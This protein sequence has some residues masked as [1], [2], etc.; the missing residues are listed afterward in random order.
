MMLKIEV[1]HPD[2]IKFIGLL[3]INNTVMTCFSLHGLRVP[4]AMD[5]V[6]PVSDFCA[7]DTRCVSKS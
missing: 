1:M 4:I 5:D 6:G 3:R 7:T 2:A